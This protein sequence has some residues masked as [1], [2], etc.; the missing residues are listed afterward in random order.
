LGLRQKLF[1]RI[2][3]K[4]TARNTQNLGQPQHNIRSF[5]AC[6]LYNVLQPIAVR[7]IHSRMVHSA[8]KGKCKGKIVPVQ[9]I[10]VYREN[11]GTVPPTLNRGT[12]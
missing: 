11:K 12:R 8:L 3:H 5:S 7:G 6:R 2:P 1:T 4:F 9:D 10:K